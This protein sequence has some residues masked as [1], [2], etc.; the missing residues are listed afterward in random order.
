MYEKQ[1]YC[2]LWA[3]ARPLVDEVHGQRGYGGC[4][5]RPGGYLGLGTRPG[6]GVEPGI[7]E[8]LDPGEGGTWM[9]G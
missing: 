1:W 9:S 2:F 7:V 4:E 6:E 3:H 8:L 5:V